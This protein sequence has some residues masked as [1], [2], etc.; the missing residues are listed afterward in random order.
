MKAVSGK[1]YTAR[2]LAAQF[3][4]DERTVQRH[5]NKM[6]GEAQNGVARLFDEAQATAILEAVK[7]GQPN[8][9]TSTATCRGMETELTLELQIALAEKEVREASE[10]AALLWKRKASENEARAVKA[11]AALGRLSME[12]H[13]VITANTQLFD[14]ATA[15]GA[16]T[17]DREDMLSTYRRDALVWR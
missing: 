2:E 4:C 5:G 14:I 12:H 11:E 15:A 6:F 3:G 1:K 7:G 16:L 9:T 17:S 13:D 10:K 8:Q